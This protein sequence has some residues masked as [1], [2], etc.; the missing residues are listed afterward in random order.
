MYSDTI[1]QIFYSQFLVTHNDTLKSEKWIIFCHITLPYLVH[2]PYGISQIYLMYVLG[3]SYPFLIYIYIIDQSQ[4][5]LFIRVE[6]V[7][8][9]VND[10]V[11]YV[12][13]WGCTHKAATINYLNGHVRLCLI[14]HIALEPLTCSGELNTWHLVI[15][16]CITSAG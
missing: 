5:V 8:N 1:F 9:H 7:K 10:H 16:L 6:S 4:D 3:V 12:M 13:Q 15:V 2:W 14:I 11:I